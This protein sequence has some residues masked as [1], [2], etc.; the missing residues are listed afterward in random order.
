MG[1]GK[2]GKEDIKIGFPLSLLFLPL[3]PFPSSPF[4]IFPFP[5]FSFPR[6]GQKRDP[7]PFLH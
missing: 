2:E 7:T 5:F 4:P 3:F 6:P 1:K